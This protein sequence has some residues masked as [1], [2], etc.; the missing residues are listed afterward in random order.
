M[1]INHQ[2]RWQTSRTK[3][4]ELPMRALAQRAGAFV[5]LAVSIAL[6]VVGKLYPQPAQ[7][8]RLAV[9]GFFTEFAHL[10]AR[11]L[12]GI[13]Q[14]QQSMGEWNGAVNENQ[15]LRLELQELQATKAQLAEQKAENTRLRALA[16]VA[17]PQSPIF[18]SARVISLAGGGAQQSL[19]IDAGEEQGVQKDMA[20]MAPEGLVGR[21]I[22]T[23]SDRARVLL[24]TDTLSRLPVQAGDSRFQAIAAGMESSGFLSLRHLPPHAELIPGEMAL[25]AGDGNLLPVGIPVGIIEPASPDQPDGTSSVASKH[26]RLRPLADLARLDMLSVVALPDKHP[27]K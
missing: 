15:R 11:P 1:S 2:A 16:K 23:G 6:L 24:L 20:V 18:I 13:R 5:C 26:W 17:P 12:D 4:A 22:E 9:T 14:A 21:V 10:L 3:T 8:A 25:T 27:G 19:W 7:H